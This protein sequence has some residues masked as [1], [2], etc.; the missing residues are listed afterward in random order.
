MHQSDPTHDPLCYS[1][2][3]TVFTRLWEQLDALLSHFWTLCGL[4][5]GK[6]GRGNTL[7]QEGD[8]TSNATS[9][10][11]W[12]AGLTQSHAH[13]IKYSSQDLSLLFHCFFFI[14]HYWDCKALCPTY[15]TL[16]SAARVSG[17]TLKRE[18]RS[19][20]D[21]GYMHSI[22]DNT[23]KQWK[24]NPSR[25]PDTEPTSCKQD[26]ESRKDVR[27]NS[28]NVL[29]PQDYFYLFYPSSQKAGIVSHRCSVSLF[30]SPYT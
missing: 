1:C 21:S 12:T 15:N 13:P 4:E 25:T 22:R 8:R 24:P 26:S 16:D 30:I 23:E 18:P 29:Q 17:A 7:P 14:F 3:I 19:F 27:P 11:A 28:H 6:T 20:G 2:R 10:L 9:S 5:K